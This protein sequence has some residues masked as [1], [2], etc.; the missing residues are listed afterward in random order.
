MHPYLVH[1]INGA[2]VLRHWVGC[3]FVYCEQ[4]YLRLPCLPLVEEEL[5]A[6]TLYHYIEG[7]DATL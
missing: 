2:A 3:C 5:V 1:T 6:H 4:I 7:V